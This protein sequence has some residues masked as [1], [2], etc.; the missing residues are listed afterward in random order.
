MNY[1]PIIIV[2]GEPYSVF[3]EIFFKAYKKIRANKILKSPIILIGSVNLLL[4][5]MKYFKFNFE[6]NSILSSQINLVKNNKKINIIDIS[7]KQKKIFEKDNKYSNKYIES[8]FNLGI[9]LM[10]KENCLGFINGPI[11]KSKFLKKKYEGITEYIATKTNSKNVSMLI[12]NKDLSTSP[13]TTHIPIRK[14]PKK[15][16]KNLIIKKI[17]L[18]NFFYKKRLKFKPKIAILGLNPHC[19]TNDNFS[20]EKEIILPS[21]SV[22]KKKGVRISGPFPADTFFLKKNIKTFDLVFGMYHDQVL[23]PIK[24]LFKFDAIN[25]TVGL[26][27]IRISPDHG[28]NYNMVGKGTSNSNSLEESIKFLSM[29]K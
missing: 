1:K 7:L 29:L 27:F 2:L 3:T 25:I 22:L 5:H 24:T 12:Y 16:S 28:P 8:S 26:P 20:E 6:I 17:L 11:S 19:E 14:V 18:L 10:L 21:I 9:K 23:T 13:I 15:I 4:K